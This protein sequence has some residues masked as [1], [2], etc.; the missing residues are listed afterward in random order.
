MQHIFCS[1][2]VP[3][4]WY[5]CNTVPLLSSTSHIIWI[6]EN[7]YLA[8]VDMFRILGFCFGSVPTYGPLARYVKLRVAHAPG[9]LGTFP[10]A[11]TSKKTAGKRSRHASRHVR[12][13]RAVMHVGIAYLGWRGKRSRHSRRMRICNLRIRQEAHCT[14]VFQG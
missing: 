2:Y 14:C 1:F 9:M 13:A 7:N 12:H 10:P 4:K 5:N 3:Y 6:G 8:V 11:P